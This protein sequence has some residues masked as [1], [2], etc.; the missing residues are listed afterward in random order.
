MAAC[1]ASMHAWAAHSD[2]SR[3]RMHACIYM[4]IMSTVCMHA[5]HAAGPHSD[6]ARPS[7][8]A[9]IYMYHVNRVHACSWAA[10][11]VGLAIERGPYSGLWPFAARVGKKATT[12]GAS[13]AAMTGLTLLEAFPAME[14][15]V[16]QL[17][18]QAD[19]HRHLDQTAHAARRLR[20]IV[21]LD[22]FWACAMSHK[23]GSQ[24]LEPAEL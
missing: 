21:C 4:C 17:F 2:E 20:R 1:N 5:C 6:E 22:S 12:K 24:Q 13:C 23:Q 11:E 14:K 8:H 18:A 7:M 3:P 19:V 9:C 16:E 15:H 10:V